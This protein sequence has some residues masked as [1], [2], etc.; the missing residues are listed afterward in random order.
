VIW[1]LV[2]FLASMSTFFKENKET[3]KSYHELGRNSCPRRL[4][5]NKPATPAITS[6]RDD[7]VT[8]PTMVT[9]IIC[10]R[11]GHG[12]QTVLLWKQESTRQRGLHDSP[13]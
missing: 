5:D 11:S 4:S 12:P 2:V 1:F 13:A 3:R 6:L 9:K 8:E 7:E 10:S